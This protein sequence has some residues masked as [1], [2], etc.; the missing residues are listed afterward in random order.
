MAAI[1][2]DAEPE[3][4]NESDAK[5]PARATLKIVRLPE[6]L[7]ID[8]EDDEDFEDSDDEEYSEEGSDDEEING[9]PSDKEKAKKRKEAAAL[10]DLEDG[11]DEDDSESEQPANIKSVISQLLKGKAPATGDED[12]DDEEEDD[13]EGLDLEEVVVCTL[14]TEKVSASCGIWIHIWMTGSVLMSA[15]ALPTNSRH[16]SCGGRANLFQSQR[17]TRRLLDRKLCDS[18]RR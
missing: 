11:M 2:P 9:G 17:Y 5:K 3:Y 18:F 12:D 8:E 10:K 14:D 7:D 6:D 1:D 15:I 16:Y 4:E 13:E